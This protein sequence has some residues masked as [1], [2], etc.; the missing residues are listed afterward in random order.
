MT[1]LII[2]AESFNTPGRIMRAAADKARAAE[3]AA[4]LCNAVLDEWPEDGGGEKPGPATPGNWEEV[5]DCIFNADGGGSAYVIV[6]QLE[7]EAP[8]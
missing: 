1:V 4:E 6:S 3:I 7:V 2:E 8:K 5:A